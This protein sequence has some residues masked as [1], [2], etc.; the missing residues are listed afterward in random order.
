MSG[1]MFCLWIK[2]FQVLEHIGGCKGNE[3]D[4]C[5]GVGWRVRPTHIVAEVREVVAAMQLVLLNKRRGAGARKL[6]GV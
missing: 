1:F 3:T 4:E 6:S 2:R 5:S